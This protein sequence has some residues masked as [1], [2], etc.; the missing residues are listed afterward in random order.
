[1][2]EYIRALTPSGTLISS[3]GEPSR[4]IGPLARIFLAQVMSRF[5]RQRLPLFVAT[6]NKADLVVLKQVIDSG[7]ATPVIDRTYALSEASEAVEYVGKRHC[8]GKVV[9]TL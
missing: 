8:R 5:V 4:W 9:I 3:S 6:R 2:S 7:E 1:M